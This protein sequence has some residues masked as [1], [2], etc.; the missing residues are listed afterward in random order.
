MTGHFNQFSAMTVLDRQNLDKI[1]DEQ[2]QSLSGNYSDDDYV[3][4]G[5]LTN[6]Q[7]ILAGMILGMPDNVVS[8]QLSITDVETGE[9]RASFIKNCIIDDLRNASV[10]KEASAELLQQMGIELTEYGR[11]AL[12]DGQSST[13]SAEASLAKGIAAQKNGSVVEALS[14]YYEAASYN[15]SL[16][17]ATSRLSV[18]SANVQNGNIG[19]SVRND[20]QQRNAWVS[21]LKECEEFYMEHLP[22]EIIYNSDLKQG[23]ID[24]TTETVDLNFSLAVMPSAGFEVVQNILDGLKKTGKKEQWGLDLWPLSSTVFADIPAKNTFRYISSQNAK[25]T[26]GKRMEISAT[27]SNNNGAVIST[28]KCIFSTTLTF[29]TKDFGPRFFGDV[30]EPYDINRMRIYPTTANLVFKSVN[31]NDITDNLT[32]RIDSVN[33]NNTNDGYAK[34]SATDRDIESYI[35]SKYRIFFSVI[36]D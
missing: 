26:A 34:I 4:I 28:A 21:V 9:R 23:D 14:Y 24:Y 33:N 27:L 10:V 1:L 6:A 36:E 7:Y 12:F 22:Y 13:V 35:R 18:L 29:I 32:I 16:S 2:Q 11:A 30:N 31:A 25:Y 20:I 8:V 17:E 19:E 15:P 5:N 3:R